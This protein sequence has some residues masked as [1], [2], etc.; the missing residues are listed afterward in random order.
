MAVPIRPSI[1]TSFFSSILFILSFFFSTTGPVGGFSHPTFSPFVP[2]DPNPPAQRPWL[3]FTGFYDARYDAHVARFTSMFS[4]LLRTRAVEDL[5]S[6]AFKSLVIR[7][8][9]TLQRSGAWDPHFSSHHLYRDLYPFISTFYDIVFLQISRN[10]P[11]ETLYLQLLAFRNT[12][13]T[14]W[15]TKG[16]RFSTRTTLLLAIT[17]NALLLMDLRFLS[18]S[19]RGGRQAAR[20]LLAANH[21]AITDIFVRPAS[22][23]HLDRFPTLVKYLILQIHALCGTVNGDESFIYVIAAGTAGYIGKTSGTRVRASFTPPSL[24]PR[25]SEHAREL[26]ATINRTVA[27]Y[28]KRN[29]YVCLSNPQVGASLGIIAISSHPE[30]QASKAEAVGIALTKFNANGAQFKHL[31]EQ[32]RHAAK[33]TRTRTPRLRA[34]VRSKLNSRNKLL[35]D[36]LDSWGADADRSTS[37]YALPEKFSEKVHAK[38]E[39]WVSKCARTKRLQETYLQTYGRLYRSSQ[40]CPGP[41]FIYDIKNFI[42]LIKAFS[43]PELSKKLNW[44]RFLVTNHL[45]TDYLYYVIDYVASFPIYRAKQRVITSINRFLV[46]MGM[47][48]NNTFVLRTYQSI[49]Q[50]ALKQWVKNS[51]DY[52]P[53]CCSHFKRFLQSRTRVVSIPFESW[54]LRLVNIQ[55]KLKSIIWDLNAENLNEKK[56]LHQGV[57]APRFRHAVAFRGCRGTE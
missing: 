37:L 41:A 50:P 22:T 21:P 27:P 5:A 9:G 42:L 49:S 7:F 34:N 55:R 26:H 11:D 31:V 51:I 24:I 20:N 3:P 1:T 18:L 35:Q 33:K 43:T 38:Y 36:K 19:N 13:F 16:K 12:I 47:Q 57:P 17:S 15:I 28:R 23:L 40:T 48:T 32:V 25:W 56:G 10:Q 52:L 14:F 8:I 54:N 45:P 29:R 53:A 4:P 46:N 6:S 2:F 30:A 44:G 39:L